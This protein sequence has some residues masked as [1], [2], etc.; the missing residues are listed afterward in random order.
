MAIMS[1]KTGRIGKDLILE[2]EGEVYKAEDVNNMNLQQ[3]HM[4]TY[5]C[6]T[7]GQLRWIQ[8]NTEIEAAHIY[9]DNLCFKL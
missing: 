5:F 2:I 3:I 4:M 8:R 1:I 7:E 6:E 9:I